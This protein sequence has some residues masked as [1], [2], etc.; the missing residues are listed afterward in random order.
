M[1]HNEIEEKLIQTREQFTSVLNNL[2]SAVYVVDIHT[3]ELLFVNQTLTGYYGKSPSEL[4][5]KPCWK[6]LNETRKAPCRDCTNPRVI[7]EQG[8]PAGVFVHEFMNKYLNRVF[9]VTDQAIQWPDER[10]VKLTIA[11]DIT[12]YKQAA[13]ALK[14]S[15]NKFKTLFNGIDD[16][17]FVHR[18][19]ESGVPNFIE[20]NDGACKR[21]GYTREEFRSIGPDNI[22][23]NASDIFE[24]GSPEHKKILSE[25]GKRVFE[26]C[27]RKK[28]G[29]IFPV[30]V[31][32]T[33]FDF[34][35]DKM[36]LSTVRDITERKLTEKEKTEALRFASQQEKY[37]L[38]G[39]VAGKM[40]HDF[41]NILGAIM[42]NAEISLM[43]CQEE[44]IIKN[45]NIILEQ[46]IR[47]KSLTQNLVAFAKDQEPR[48]EHFNIN[49]KIE[50]ILNLL[51]KDLKDIQVVK[52]FTPDLPE[53][54]ADPGMIE[55]ALVNLVQNSVHAM[56]RV[57]DKRLFVRTYLLE[58]SLV[59]EIKDTGCGIPEEYLDAIYSPAFTLKGSR[60]FLGAYDPSIKGTGYGMSN[61]KKYI[62]KHK[63]TIAFESRVNKGTIFT[64]TLPVVQKRL[65]E[66][67]KERVF[68]KKISK[69]KKILLVE[70]EIAISA[71]QYKILT[72]EP[73]CHDVRIAET[74]KEAINAFNSEPFDLVSLDYLLSGNLN[75]LDV[76]RHIREKNRD[77]P[78]VFI[79]GNIGFLE[80]MKTLS[81]SDK[82]MDHISKPC[83]NIVYANTINKWL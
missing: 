68:Q 23:V 78:I 27:H 46:A 40:A 59:I 69:G 83:S 63:G 10:M 7:D 19:M 66:K 44:E 49:L 5:G 36:V 64:V 20:V 17:V 58:E 53:L 42:G 51:R 43:D 54:L 25:Q 8:R 81:G 62:E 30:E 15:E 77:I 2:N 67:E 13:E 32:A 45:L 47:G 48:E 60:D 70:D 34:H 4:I 33:L 1:A 28:N 16:A 6:V 18:F 12:G 31:S 29:E 39:Q 41:N 74:G 76:Y 72:Q 57:N 37:A 65:S 56:S 52:N 80:S 21:Y 11:R 24:L 71:V 55:H 9:E 3:Y 14:E 79:S 26:V 50:L 35:G 61:V 75:G 82:K 38:V 73:L 22:H